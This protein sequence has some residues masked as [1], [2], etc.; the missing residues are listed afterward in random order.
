MFCSS[1]PRTRVEREHGVAAKG[2]QT[3]AGLRDG[4]AWSISA[5][6]LGLSRGSEDTPCA[7]ACVGTV[8]AAHAAVPWLPVLRT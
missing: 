4:A 5:V 2:W 6:P 7:G 8:C 3:H 1:R